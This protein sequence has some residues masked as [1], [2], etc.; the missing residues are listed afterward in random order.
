M[1]QQQGF[2]LIELIVVI[3]ILGIL[4]ATALPKFTDLSSDAKL[5]AVQGVA[6][7]IASSAS[8]QKSANAISSVAY[9]YAAAS[10][11][12]GSYL[13][14]GIDATVSSV[15]SGQVCT[16]RNLATTSI[17]KAVTLP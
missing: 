3:V 11:C 15:L 13:E 17:T 12:S 10:A 4:A 7:A 5:A 9:P 2:T 1:K 8:I 6:G 14:T 16:V